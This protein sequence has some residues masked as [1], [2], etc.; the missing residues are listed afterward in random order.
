[1]R[2][3][4]L[5][6]EWKN[7]LMANYEID[8]DILRP[9]LPS[10]TE[11]DTFNGVHYVSLVGF[12]FANTKVMGLSFP[13]HRTF[14]EV[15]LRFYVRYKEGGAWKRGVVFLKEIVPKHIISFVANTFYGENYKT[16]PMRHSYEVNG[17]KIK[18]SYKWKVGREW[19]FMN[20]TAD[21]K[22]E[23]FL[24]CSEEE[25]ITEHYWGYTFI[26]SSCSGAYEVQH[27]QWNIH[28]VNDHE[29]QCD[30]TALYGA[31]FAEALAVRPK[32][33]FLATGS[34]VTVFKGTKIYADLSS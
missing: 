33:I 22:A 2:K 9:Y 23:R 26:N 25:F 13:F 3:P 32:S 11:L 18:V 29:I 4:F 1:M 24:Q 34:P 21:R 14:E 12:V 10:Q 28:T 19:N 6:A 15:N 30:A 17:D 16:H 8:P 7:L 31:G 27:P 5:T 20:A